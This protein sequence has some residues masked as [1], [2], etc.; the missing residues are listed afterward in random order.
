MSKLEFLKNQHLSMFEQKR[1]SHKE[2]V[3]NL[4]NEYIAGKDVDAE[5]KWSLYSNFYL[6]F[7]KAFPAEIYEKECIDFNDIYKIRNNFCNKNF[8]RR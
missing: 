1:I 6:H 5:D 8:G 3:C 4:Y 2:L 7:A